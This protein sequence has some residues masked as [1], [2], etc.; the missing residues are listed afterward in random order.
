MEMHEVY[1]CESIALIEKQQVAELIA[2]V[3]SYSE[4]LA[5]Q[6]VEL[7]KDINNLSGK[8]SYAPY[9]DLHS[10]IFRNFE[11]YPVYQEHKEIIE[12]ILEYDRP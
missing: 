5:K 2:A 6:I 1:D 4:D 3:L 12:A 7:R 10:D 9:I 8:G 11:H